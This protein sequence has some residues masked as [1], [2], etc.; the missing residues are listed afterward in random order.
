RIGLDE[1]AKRAALPGLMYQE[2]E[3]IAKADPQDAES[4]VNLL[5]QPGADVLADRL[6]DS[7]GGLS[8]LVCREAVLFAAGSTDARID[9]RE[10]E[11]KS[12][13]VIRRK[14]SIIKRKFF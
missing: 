3:A 5:R 10:E 6:M 12:T 13:L 9:P 14:S 8:P 7:F 2:P 11:G 1:S 4:Y